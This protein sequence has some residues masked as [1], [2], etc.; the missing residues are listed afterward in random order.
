MQNI[1]IIINRD[2]YIFEKYLKV[3]PMQKPFKYFLYF[4]IKYK[5][6]Q[7]D[8]YILIIRKLCLHVREAKLY[9]L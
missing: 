1:L 2:I 7:G 8:K 4:S 9:Y 6:E 3:N 5:I